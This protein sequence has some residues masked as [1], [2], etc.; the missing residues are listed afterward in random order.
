MARHARAEVDDAVGRSLRRD[1]FGCVQDLS[2]LDLQRRKWLDPANTN[3]H[4]SYIEFCC[5]YPAG[6]QLADALARGWLAASEFEILSK[7]GQAISAHSAPGGDDY[8]NAAVLKDPA[9]HEVVEAAKR[10]RQ[11]LFAMAK[12]RRTSSAVRAPSP[13]LFP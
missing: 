5:S 12:R 4:W 8:D 1:W 10:T 13:N 11:Q 3:P 6:S 7:L 9:W 2:D